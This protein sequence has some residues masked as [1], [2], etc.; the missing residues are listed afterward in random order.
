MSKAKTIL[1]T[2]IVICLLPLLGS[3]QSLS[4]DWRGNINIMGQKLHIIT[5]FQKNDSSYS[6]TI[7]IP[8][9][10]AKGLGLQNISR[11][12]TDSISFGFPA[13][14]GYASFAG[15]FKSDSVISG[16]FSQNGR[17]FSFELHRYDKKE[18][19]QA[20]AEQQKDL[21]YHHKD[22][23]IKNDSI[24][25]GGTLTWPKNN[26]PEQLVIMMS[27]SGAQDRDETLRPLSDFKP[28]AVL[29][30]SLTTSNIATFRYDDRGVGQSTGSFGN[31]TLQML[32]SDV[33]AII[34]YLTKR[35]KH[36]FKKII[37]LGH[38]QGGIV[39]GRVAAKNKKVDKLILMASPSL[40]LDKILQYQLKQN[41]IQNGFEEAKVEP[42]LSAFQ[43]ALEAIH[44]ENNVKAAK[45]HYEKKI[46]EMFRSLPNQ[47]KP[48]IANFDSAA[49]AQGKGLL[50]AFTN[51]Q[52]QSLLFYDPTNDL[53]KLDIPV[54]ALF[55]GKDVQ[56][57]A[58]KNKPP[59]KAALESAGVPYRIE[60]FEQ[61]NHLFQKADTGLP[62]EYG[63][64]PNQFLDKFTST[65][66]EWINKSGGEAANHK[67]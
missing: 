12:E 57:L 26:K 61:A 6:G 2:L 19:E 1:S 5:H 25:I 45:K 66:I 27:G 11:T 15:I 37:L 18:E 39:G 49:S 54:L 17:Q 22:L 31:T 14:P 40:T 21:P 51:P 34:K 28:F 56:V 42:A 16:T 50:Q 47:N 41:F 9:Q 13:G 52:M 20:K 48:Q 30:D 29:A 32:A 36:N 43:K 3:A 8:Q 44:N 63:T 58:G 7:D 23:I 64:L 33:E 59:I 38:S 67:K 35:P 4:G 55:G 46:G 10:G 62:Q 65:I 60:V 24:D 53:K